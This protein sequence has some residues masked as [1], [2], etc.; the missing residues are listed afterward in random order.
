MLIQFKKKKKMGAMSFMCF[1]IKKNS[2]GNVY[3]PV[4]VHKQNMGNLTEVKEA[5]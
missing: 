4:P 1:M 2:D 3:A 5:F